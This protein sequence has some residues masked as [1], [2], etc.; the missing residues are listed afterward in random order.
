MQKQFFSIISIL[1]LLSFLFAISSCNLDD[2]FGGGDDSG[3]EE[4]DGQGDETAEDGG[5]DA[6]ENPCLNDGVYDEALAVCNCVSGYSGDLCDTE[7]A[8][9]WRPSITFSV[10]GME[11][12]PAA[13]AYW[14]FDTDET[15]YSEDGGIVSNYAYVAM[16]MNEDGHGDGSCPGNADDGSGEQTVITAL[17]EDLDVID[18]VENITMSFSQLALESYDHFNVNGDVNWMTLGEAGDRRT[19][20]GG[21]GD[22]Y[23]NGELVLKITDMELYIAVIYPT[24]LGPGGDT[25]MAYGIGLGVIDTENSNEDWVTQFSRNEANQV[26]F[27]FGSMSPVIQLCYGTFDVSELIF[28]PVTDEATCDDLT[29]DTDEDG[30]IDLFDQE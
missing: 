14:M 2:M 17:S 1:F 20:S 27:L 3:Q 4:G 28:R 7:P 24:P 30:L 8:A 9:C 16:Q 6:E 10:T 21:V 25:G 15:P 11:A 19:Y 23:E 26:E 22:I 18:G 5:D 29:L 13:L 12:G